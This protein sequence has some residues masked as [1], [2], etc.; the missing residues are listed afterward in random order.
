[1][2]F[3]VVGAFVLGVL[4]TSGAELLFAQTGK[5]DAG[6]S[7]STRK[8]VR[9][10]SAPLKAWLAHAKH[11]KDSG[12]LDLSVSRA[13]TVEADR[14]D[15]GTL[16]NAVI[17][18]ASASEP[19]FRELAQVFVTAL[20]DSHALSFLQD[21][22]RVRMTFAL[23]GERFS[24]DVTSAT[25]SLQR[26]EEMVR[27]YRAMINVAR[28]MQR[29]SDRAVVLNNMKISSSGKQLVMSLVMSREQVGNLLLKQITPN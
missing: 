29:G 2:R 25:P 21:V 20:N 10:N 24:S 17:S 13:I 22:S 6:V 7:A 14:A 23:D 4:P 8:P 28:L 16:S 1:M 18:G 11:Q 26:A 19:Q 3:V 9:I 27:G 5:T 15:D 12:K